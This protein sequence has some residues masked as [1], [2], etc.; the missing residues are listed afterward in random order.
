MGSILVEQADDRR[1]TLE[2]NLLGTA[3]LI[4]AVAGGMRTRRWGRIV[5]I[6]SEWGVIGWPNAAAYAA[7]KGGIIS[8][9]RSAAIALAPDG[10]AVNAVAPGVT[11]TSQLNVDATDA[12]VSHAEIVERYAAMTPLGRIG[13]VEDIASVVTLLCSEAAMPF[14]GQVIQPNGGTTRAR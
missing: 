5:A 7:S 8:L 10:I 13:S 1:R 14:V 12:G 3:W 2:V 6:A 11:N 4:G 9:V